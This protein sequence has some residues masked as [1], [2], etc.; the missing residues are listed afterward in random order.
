MKRKLLVALCSIIVWVAVGFAIFKFVI[1]AEGD[2]KYRLNEDGE[3]FSVYVD[4][5]Y[6][7]D[8]WNREK[9]VV[10]PSTYKGKPVTA[11]Y[12]GTFQSSETVISV[13]IPDSVT[14]IGYYCFTRCSSLESV[15]IPDTIIEVGTGFE[16][17]PLLK[18]NEYDN[19]L[20]LGNEKNPYVV[21]VKAVDKEITRCEIHPDTKAIA[22]DAFK[23]CIWL[24]KITIPDNVRSIGNYAFADCTSLEELTY[25]EG[26]VIIC[27]HAFYGCE[28]LNSVSFLGYLKGADCKLSRIDGSAFSNCHSLECIVIPASVESMESGVFGNCP[29]KIYCEAESQPIGW[30]QNWAGYTADVV[31]NFSNK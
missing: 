22:A 19:A 6:E 18:F 31:W 21:L 5:E 8:T 30:D 3:S 16:E 20:Y 7:Y 10:I 2:L 9:N 29:A 17:S 14:K 15:S 27:G 23:D 1:V 24:K 12:N 28:K 11:L 26:L 13:T 25:G 4:N